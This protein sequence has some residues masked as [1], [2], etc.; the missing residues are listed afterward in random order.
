MSFTA[1]L[2]RIRRCIG[3]EH[4]VTLCQGFRAWLAGARVDADCVE[5]GCRCD[6]QTGSA[7][8]GFVQDG[9]LSLTLL[10][11]LDS[12]GLL[13]W[14]CPFWCGFVEPDI[15][16]VGTARKGELEAVYPWL[17]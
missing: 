9:F 15:L 7:A 13:D 5:T 1:R 11:F 8:V 12:A 14:Q 2:G 17:D 4:S 3:H 16:V 6:L 10:V